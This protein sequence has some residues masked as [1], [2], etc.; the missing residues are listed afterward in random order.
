MPDLMTHLLLPY[1]LGRLTG[2]PQR[3]PSAWLALFC[4]GA[5]L[6]DLLNRAPGIALPSG[7]VAAITMPFHTPAGII[8]TCLA[9]AFVFPEAFRRQALGALLCGAGLHLLLDAFQRSLDAG[10]YY[11]LFPFSWSKGQ[12]G[13]FWPDETLLALPFLAAFCLL[14]E[15]V[16]QRRWARRP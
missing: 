15:A 3:R 1:G 11:W 6:P 7:L 9:L 10:S 12:I 5:V 13:L 16:A 2:R 4:L 14:A 8:V